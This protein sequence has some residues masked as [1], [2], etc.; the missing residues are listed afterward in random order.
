MPTIRGAVKVRFGG[1]TRGT[2]PLVRAERPASNGP[3]LADQPE[4]IASVRFAVG[5]KPFTRVP[6][7][8]RENSSVDADC[9]YQH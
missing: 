6:V 9:T 1:H 3:H 4:D 5:R 2:G 7:R 8:P